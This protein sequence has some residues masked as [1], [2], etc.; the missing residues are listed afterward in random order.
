MKLKEIKDKSE[1]LSFF[2]NFV[3][4]SKIRVL[5]S[6][7]NEIK[8]LNNIQ[9]LKLANLNLLNAIEE[10]WFTKKGI[11]FFEREDNS[12]K[13]QKE[14]HIYFVVDPKK[15]DIY[16]KNMLEKMEET[17][18]TIVTENDF[19]VTFGIHVNT[20]CQKL[21]LNIIEHFDYSFFEDA[22]E[23]SQKMSALIEIGVKN[24]LFT[25]AVMMIAQSSN[26]Q[27]EPI[28]RKQILPFENIVAKQVAIDDLSEGESEK[29]YANEIGTVE[30][31]KH[32]ISNINIG[33]AEWNPDIYVFHEQFTKT[34]IKQSV[35]EMKVISKVEQFNLELQLLEEK[36]NKLSEQQEMMRMLYNRVRKEESTMQS[37]LLY[38]AF[39]LREEEE[40]FPL[41]KIK[42]SRE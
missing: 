9:G 32:I 10:R 23:L 16:S 36:K 2:V 8:K 11:S 13:K 22:E 7:N 1:S 6:L 18:S 35:H 26:S 34:I 37:L 33:K 21:E 4:I 30:D 19:I 39:K 17:L 5:Q 40:E 28:I 15:I 42:G 14:S 27:S 41:V 20:I 3:E 38:S 12:P 29:K 25:K 24:N 31:Y